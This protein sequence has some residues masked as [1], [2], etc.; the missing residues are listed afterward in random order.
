MRWLQTEYILKG[1]YLGLVLFAA[2]QQA[3]APRD[4]YWQTL[5][6]V[7]LGTLGGLALALGIAAA[8]KLREGYRVK[9]RLI[10]F[11][12]FLLLESPTLVYAGI[13]GGTLAGIYL[14]QQAASTS[15]AEL[16]LPA[17]G[18]GAAVGILFGMIRQV[19]RPPY[20]RLGLILALAASLVSGALLWLGLIGEFGTPDLFK[21][22]TVFGIQILLGIPFFYILTFAGHEEETE[23]EIGAMCAALG[24]GL[25]T[26]T[27]AHLQLRAWFRSLSFLLPM[28]LYVGYTFRVLPGL[29]VLKHAFRGISYARVGR[30]RRSLQ[31]FRRALAL[32]PNNKFARE[33]FWNV[34]RSLDLE[35]LINDPQTLALVDL[36]LCLDRAGSLLLS[37]R[38]SPVHLEEAHRLLDMVLRLQPDRR[39]AVEYW[40]A[41]A[42]T[43]GKLYDQ[44]AADLERILDPAHYGPANQ[45]RQSIL[46]SAWQLALLLHEELRRRVGTPQLALPGRR[47]EAIAAVE[48][49]LAEHPGDEA[50]FG[51]KRVLYQD[52]T[53]A[54]YDAFA[55]PGLATPGFDHPYA[56]ELGLA[57]INDNARWQRGGEYL[58]LAARGL[59]AQGP[60]LF[61]Q[62]AKA[63]QRAGNEQEA[64]RGFEMAK[65]AGR[66]VG[67]KNLPDAERQAYFATVKFLAETA[68]YHGDVDAAIENFHLYTESERSGLETLR[69]LAELYEKKGD[70]LS[71][72]RA[73]D[74]ALV[75]NPKDKDLLERKDRYYYSVMPEQ[76][77]ARLD[78]VRTGFDLDYCL[79]K[80]RTIL[81]GR[82]TEVEWLDV[83]RHLIELACIV[84]P[85][86][87]TAKVLQARVRLRY[88]ER[89]EALA[90]LES[91]RSPKPEK[92]NSGEDEEAWYFSCQILGDMYLEL[93]RADLAV[94]C[95]V[96]FRKSSKSGARTDLKLAQAYE[97]LGDRPRAV[98]AYQRVTA[99]DGNPLAS[100]ARDA[101]YRLQAR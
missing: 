3:A 96:D 71:A 95:L 100:E 94:P 8:A 84:A 6:Y 98:K 5:L 68:L 23:V 28:L 25:V 21:D 62:I 59:P 50:I 22:P 75:Y 33:G 20:A 66:S 85:A 49:H 37:P 73:T 93:G 27:Q 45:Y 72:L 97:Q 76:L 15:V 53:E 101:L 12:L 10:V 64:L 2:L 19:E 80:T 39:P 87:L 56:Q 46:V 92:F 35:Q 55:G 26:I 18:G 54:D 36:N 13:L 65:R 38:P 82:H 58:R 7:N 44:A 14:V 61:V 47:M 60:G 42:H 78:S 11:L 30:Y 89:D 43:H 70:A 24:L 57:L 40:R 4:D 67:A 91:V 41:V 48:R 88:G 16:F 52:V 77:Q 83:A 1:V 74:M 69:T 17:V 34:H 32:D 90:L 51:L 29:R 81:D 79:N 63:H 99:Y 31:A 9:G 86:S